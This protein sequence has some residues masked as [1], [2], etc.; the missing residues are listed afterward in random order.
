MRTARYLFSFL[1]VASLLSVL[2]LW[3]GCGG[4]EAAVK[5][6][7]A[8]RTAHETVGSEDYPP[9]FAFVEVPAPLS[10][11]N[12]CCPEPDLPLPETGVPFEDACYSTLITRV[13]YAEGINGRHEYSRL[14]PFN[15]DA[16][17]I[18]L[19]R[20]DG[21]YAVYRTDSCPYNQEGNLVAVT[22][23]MVEPRWDREDPEL[24]WGLDGLRVVAYN[25]AAG[26]REVAKDFAQDPTVAPILESEPDIYG[27]SM[28]YE[29]EASYDFRYW[30][31]MLQGEEDDYRPRYI[32]CWDR[33]GDEVLG[34]Y[35]VRPEESD[36]DWVG[37][38]PLGE[39]VL[40]GG[41]EYNRGNLAG[42][43]IADRG[44]KSFHRIDYT[45]SHADVGL[46]AE[47]REVVVM[48]NSRTDY[49]D[50]LPL[51]PDT[52]PILEAG[53]GYEGAGR[54]PLLRLFYDGDSP[55]GFSSGVHISCNAD[56]Y[57]LVSTHIEPGM[58]E[59]NWLDRGNV[60]VRLDPDEPRAFYLSKIYNTTGEYWEET[61]GA[62]SNDGSR[63][64][65]ASNWNLD[66]GSEDAFLLQLDMPLNW[67]ELT[68]ASEDQ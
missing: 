21:D 54:I 40:I 51:S 18:L 10:G 23:G 30:A 45:T 22:S 64:V 46:D 44:L 13:T 35:E 34:L 50:M 15:A 9:G 1:A 26:E 2:A 48:Q 4:E 29:G 55:L 36:I 38:S 33:E 7:D 27:V 67:R 28:N 53:G 17:M 61:H 14:D 52:R 32:L 41:M 12:P 57:C 56:G 37:M 66:P 47:G 20:D 6:G 43:T 19:V 42:L 31:F 49:I 65:W 11:D 39:W 58:P 59:R 3:S 24:L 25:V 62:M 68:V 60:L 63:I 5:E 16:S 8:G